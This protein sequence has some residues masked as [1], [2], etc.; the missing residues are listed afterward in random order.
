MFDASRR[1]LARIAVL[2]G[3]LTVAVGIA[4]PASAQGL[5]DTPKY[6]SIVVDANTGEVLYGLRADQQRFPA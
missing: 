4:A 3:A 2:V 5:F 6:A 1:L